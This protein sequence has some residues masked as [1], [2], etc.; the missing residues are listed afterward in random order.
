[1]HC[2]YVSEVAT[3]LTYCDVHLIEMDY[4]KE[5][6]IGGTWF[7]ALV[8]DWIEADLNASLQQIVRGFYGRNDWT[9]MVY[10]NREKSVVWLEV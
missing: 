8:F 3:D 2:Y 9:S 4:R 7:Y 10:V 5:K 1:M 6:I